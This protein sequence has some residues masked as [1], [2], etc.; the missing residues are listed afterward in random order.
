MNS[1]FSP[2]RRGVP[3]WD[4][5]TELPF[6]SSLEIAI[7]IIRDELERFLEVEGNT[8]ALESDFCLVLKGMWTSSAVAATNLG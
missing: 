6:V 4:D 3:W 8:M 5:R 1:K 7:P 2:G